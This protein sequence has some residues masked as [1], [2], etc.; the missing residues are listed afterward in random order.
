MKL[1]PL[2][3]S[4]REYRRPT[5]ITPLLVTLEVVIEC[6]IPFYIADLVDE[7]KA[8]SP[9]EVI[10]HYGLLLTLCALLSLL[11]GSL[12]GLTCSTAA[13]GL[14]KNLRHDVFASIQSFSFGNID[15]FLP[16]SLV[17]RMTTD[18]SN[19]QNAFLMVIRIAIRAPLMMIFAFFMSWKMGGKLA[20]IFAV[21]L[22]LLALVIILMIRTVLPLFKKV[23]TKYDGV[24]ESIEGNLRG[25][26]VVKSFVRE[27]YE[28]QKF[29]QAAEELR[30]DFTRVE[31]ILAFNGPMMQ[32][33]MYLMNIFVMTA[34]SWT[35]ISSLG[36]NLNIGQYSA[37]L[38]YSAMMLNS[39]MMVSMVFVMVIISEESVKRISE[40]L[41]ESSLIENPE[42]PI[43]EVKNGQIDFESVSFKYSS[44]AE[45]PVLSDISLSIQSGETI[46]LVGATGSAKSSLV[47]LIPRLYDTTAG[48]VLVAGQDVRQY[49]LKTLRDSVAMVLQKNVLFSGT[50][51]SN[52]L[53]GNPTATDE[54][55]HQALKLA[56]AEE[57]VQ[58][59]PEGLDAK[60]DQG[61]ANFS[62]GQRQRLCIARALV[63]QPKI[64]ILDD[65]TSACDVRTD[66]RIRE[67][68]STYLPQ[69]TKII[70]AQRLSSVE[71][72]DRIVVLEEGRI[73][74][75]GTHQEL[76]NTCALYQEIARSQNQKEVAS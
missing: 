1:K 29:T 11:F 69:T 12:A 44:Q 30:A 24:N 53:W 60:V 31:R 25:I 59:L 37:L 45:K 54:E 9:L 16:S 21:L 38:T 70:I 67:S 3:A 13:C 40:V 48:R 72:C 65:S 32:F 73:Q 2:I 75:V 52:L 56:E 55:L 28:K 46:G 39:L 49:D 18:I 33:S 4:L 76:M 62:G 51:R 23:F 74:A 20:L 19:V 34:G 58:K 47:Q 63:R 5:L 50:L 43:R 42:K 71:G 64:L 61:G 17:T 15:H 10:L 68:L 8:G 7:I 14:A 35:I 22:P 26:R 6:A 66:A 57:F 41:S 27:D 36:L